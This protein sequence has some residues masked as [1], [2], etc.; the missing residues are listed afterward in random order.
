MNSDFWYAAQGPEIAVPQRLRELLP[1]G[2]SL[3]PE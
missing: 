3:L 1:G 2:K